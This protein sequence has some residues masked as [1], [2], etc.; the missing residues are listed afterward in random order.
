MIMT[1]D[2]SFY[3]S[4][5]AI[6]WPLVFQ[7]II[8][9]AVNVADNIMLGAYSE[10]ALAGASSVN[11]LQFILQCLVGG[12]G[13]GLTVLGSQYW[14]QKR[15]Q[16]IKK[17]CSIAFWIAVAF[18]AVIFIACTVAPNGVLNIFIDD[19]EV[20]TE[21]LKYLDV[22]KYSY[23]IFA[24]TSVLLSS[25]N[26]VE[27]VRVAFWVSVM[28]LV[29]NIGLNAVLIPACG[30]VGAAWA[31]LTSRVA[32]LVYVIVYIAIA[33]KK[34]RLRPRDL[35]SFDKALCIDF[36]KVSAPV[37]AISGMWGFS[38]AIT[39]IILGHMEMSKAVVAANSA[40][41]TLY[42]LF[43]AGAQGAANA[44]GIIMAKTV[45]AGEFSKVKEYA[46]SLQII[47]V[48]IGLITALLLFLTKDLVLS[49]YEL[50]P[51]AMTFAHQFILVLTVC[52]LGMAYQMP[53]ITGIIRGGGDT[54]FGM[55]NDL[56]SI[57]GIVLPVSALAAYV[58]KWPPVAV[59]ACLNSDQIFKCGAACFRCNRFRWV[60]KLTRDEN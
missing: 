26:C 59:V 12:V 17:L 39:A 47:F 27:T 57:W 6:F 56:V 44:A 16:P 24:I 1:R 42:N 29:I 45:G 30:S 21:G 50:S 7:N 54:R 5:T 25:L 31:T 20:I 33:D 23:I 40:A 48:C 55:Y 19:K 15:V 32:A 52:T 37:V 22:L 49:M 9:L 34:L 14:G 41:Y 35:L 46:R 2:K 58:F 43:K 3:Q 4:F 10:A 8:N 13:G 28:T 18:A 53:T 11:Q 36:I 38:N 51:E 60:K